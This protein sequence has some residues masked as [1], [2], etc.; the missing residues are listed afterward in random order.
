[1]MKKRNY[2]GR[3]LF[4]V[5]LSF[6]IGGMCQAQTIEELKRL[7]IGEKGI[8]E[9]EY[10]DILNHTDNRTLSSYTGPLKAV[11]LKKET[12]NTPSPLKDNP[13]MWPPVPFK[14]VPFVPVSEDDL[15]EEDY[16]E[17]N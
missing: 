4:I 17:N 11:G 5:L 12:I 2:K 6:F 14:G 1:M 16:D 13:C 15:R 8:N 3:A 7:P 10:N 9:I